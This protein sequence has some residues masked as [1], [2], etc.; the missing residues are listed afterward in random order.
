MVSKTPDNQPAAPL[1]GMSIDVED[2]FHILDCDT[3]PDPASWDRQPARV[4]ANTLRLLDL[5]DRHRCKATLFCLGWVAERHPDLIAEAV[6]RGHEVG[7]HGHLHG[8]VHQLGP[9]A[10][11]RDLDQSLE[12]LSKAAGREITAFRAPGFSIR[13][14]DLWALDVLISRGITL[15]SSLF[16]TRRAHGGFDLDRRGPFEVFGRSGRMVEVPV[17]PRP[18][19]SLDLAWSGGGYLRLL[20]E[21]VLV[22]SM[23]DAERRGESVNLYLHPRE[24]DVAQPRMSLPPLR[25]FKYYVGLDTVEAKLALLLEKFRFGTL[26]EVVASR[27]LEA[28]LVLDAGHWRAVA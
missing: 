2:W 28:P 6:R 22:D 1:H 25:S 18:V 26:S 3:A 15:D 19:G 4:E 17:V 9:A 16:L 8:L 24:I 10:F 14:A 27:V 5:L 7:S 13:N 23:R 12:A 11:A 21:V 20:P